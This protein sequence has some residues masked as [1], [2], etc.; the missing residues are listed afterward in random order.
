MSFGVRLLGNRLGRLR[1]SLFWIGLELGF[2]NRLD[3]GS[4]LAEVV[5]EEEQGD[6]SA[7][8]NREPRNWKDWIH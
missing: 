5:S 6:E 8:K 4:S 3:F 1:G 2:G 7:E